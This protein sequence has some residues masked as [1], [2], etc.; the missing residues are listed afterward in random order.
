[1]VH[2]VLA[3]SKGNANAVR[4]FPY[5]GHLGLTPLKVEGVVIVKPDNGQKTLPAKSITVSVRCYESRLGRVGVVQSNVLVD[6]SR[7]LWSK[8]DGVDFEDVAEMELPFR[9]SIPTQ[10]GGFSTSTFVEYRCV[11]RVEA[12]LNHIPISGVGSRQIKHS[13]LAVSRYDVPP[14]LPSGSGQPSLSLQTNKPRSARIN[15]SINSPTF[16]VGPLDLVSI[17]ISLQPLDPAISIRSASLVVERRIQLKQVTA[18]SSSTPASPSMLIPQAP[19]FSS[20]SYSPTASYQDSHHFASDASASAPEDLPSLYYENLASSSSLSSNPTITPHTIYPST[21]SVATER[22]LFPKAPEVIPSKILSYSVAEAESSG[23]FTV[24]DGIWSKTMTIQWPAPKSNSRWAIGETICSDL[25][26]VRFFIRIKITVTTPSGNETVDLQ[27]KELLVL[28]VND[29]ERHVALSK[30]NDAL[31]S[32]SS[33]HNSRSKSKSPR[34]TKKDRE[35][36]PVPSPASASRADH[37]HKPSSAS[38]QNYPGSSK[39]TSPRRPH[40]SAGPRDKVHSFTAPR[41]DERNLRAA[42]PEPTEPAGDEDGRSGAMFKRWKSAGPPSEKA[43]LAPSR[44][45]TAASGSSTSSTSISASMSTS[46][47]SSSSQESDDVKEWEKELAKIEVR[48]RRSSDMLGFLSKR[49]RPLVQ[50]TA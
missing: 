50:G 23:P 32:S 6:H 39:T 37:A 11:W 1:M 31:Y 33:D 28:G 7:V 21:S 14:S 19:S 43:F 4:Y 40:T 45:S 18:S 46:S 24:S 44:M 22:P 29:S 9:I 30:Y 10:V 25:V 49:K 5:T 13:E 16:A 38:T 48:S 26:S 20:I 41:R 42:P 15:Y 36:P 3:S 34:R 12:I 35:R 47:V 2:I 8:P 27:E 17:P